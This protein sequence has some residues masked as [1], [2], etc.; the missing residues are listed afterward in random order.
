VSEEPPWDDPYEPP[1]AYQRQDPT[2]PQGIQGAARAAE[3][4]LL[5]HLLANPETAHKHLT[6]LDPTD[7][8]DPRHE[9]IWNT[10]A[11]LTAAGH[12]PDHP[13]LIQRLTATPDALRQ[14]GGPAYLLTLRDEDPGIPQTDLWATTIRDAAGRR[15]LR[16]HLTTMLQRLDT[17]QA[18]DLHHTLA[19]LSDAAD[20]AATN[21]GPTNHGPT[22]WAPLPLDTVLAGGELDPP[23]TILART[24]GRF[25]LYDQAVHTFS[26]EPSSGKTWVTLIA[27]VQLL[28]TDDTVT[29]IDFEDRASRVVGRLLALGAHPDQI[30]KHFRYVRPRNALDHTSK[31]DLDRAVAG[32]RLVIIDG[33]TEAMTL[34]G[35]DLNSN[36]DAALFYDL[37]PRHIADQGPAVALID[38]VVKD[39]EKQGRWSLGAGH[40]LAGIDGVAYQVKA[41]EPFGRGKV[42]RA[43]LTV[44]KDR[45]GHVED[46]LL[47]RT[48]AELTLD[49]TNELVLRHTLAAASALPT[50]DGG[51]LRPTVLMER[52]SRWLEANPNTT[53]RD[54][55]AAV[56]G[57]R[58][59]VRRALQTLI[60]EGHIEVETGP[61]NA[62]YH[63]VTE[64][65]R[66]D[67]DTPQDTPDEP[68]RWDQR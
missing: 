35:Y 45:A 63:R 22:E 37:L 2:D 67:D 33:V 64:P 39:Q 12:I 40:K 38:H 62:R 58:D 43:R 32:A 68:P 47:G 41:I 15:R 36:A 53:G 6:A 31:A 65:Y 49:A 7:L 50:D 57:K 66:T 3:L 42:G 1:D 10:V 24:D 25:L 29:M 26:G 5:G 28:E 30:R 20:Y 9:L 23:P 55:E 4:A 52:V 60:H 56:S 59:Y 21:F 54:I 27:A 11:D 18:D 51:S 44:S 48:A 13:T 17:T 8:A 14:A 34:H 16:G 46:I 61:R 19:D